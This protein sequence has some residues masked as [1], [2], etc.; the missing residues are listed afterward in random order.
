MLQDPLLLAFGDMEFPAC[1]PDGAGY[2]I[3]GH[4]R[5]GGG[6]HEVNH[7]GEACLLHGCLNSVLELHQE[8]PVVR[9]QCLVG[10]EPVGF[11]QFVHPSH[12]VAACPGII[13]DHTVAADKSVDKGLHVDGTGAHLAVGDDHA[14]LHDVPGG[15]FRLQTCVDH[16]Q[17]H[18]AVRDLA[19]LKACV[20]HLPY[21]GQDCGGNLE[22]VQAAV[23]V[24]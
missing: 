17:V 11:L 2:V 15:D 16:F 18:H 23:A 20:F 4:L 12:M 5:F 19:A 14:C 3:G 24:A 8:C 9:F 1:H 21:D 7:T 13:D 6:L 10:V 22:V